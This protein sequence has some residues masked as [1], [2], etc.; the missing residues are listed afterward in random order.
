MAGV[1]NMFANLHLRRLDWSFRVYVKRIFEYRFSGSEGFTLE[2]V[3]QDSEGVRVYASIP[4]ALVNRWVGVIKEFKMYQMSFFIVVEKKHY[5]RF[6]NTRYTLLFSHMTQVVPV[7]E[8]SFPL[9]VFKFKSFPDLL[10]AEQ[11]DES[12][13]FDIMGEVVGK[14]EPREV[15]TSKGVRVRMVVVLED[16]GN[17]RLCCVFFGPLSN[18]DVSG[19]HINPELKVVEEF[20]HILMAGETSTGVRIT[21]VQGQSG[22]F[23]G[24][25]LKK[26]NT[27]VSSDAT[28][29]HDSLALRQ[30]HRIK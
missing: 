27:Y 29:P 4:K 18:F 8:P 15:L 2:M 20:R 26:G 22:I 6:T 21:Q 3:L 16:L 14:E 24:Q 13:M 9:D 25:E 23:G 5:I 28:N 30:V 12:E 1:S 10:S 17:N 11:V 7:Q 19:M